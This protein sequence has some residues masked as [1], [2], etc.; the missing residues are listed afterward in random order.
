MNAD[1]AETARSGS[2]YSG[3]LGDGDAARGGNQRTP[4][5][6][7]FA[8][9]LRC[10]EQSGSA[11]ACARHV[12]SF[13]ACERAVFN[14]VRRA[15]PQVSSAHLVAHPPLHPTAGTRSHVDRTLPPPLQPPSGSVR[16]RLGRD[17][18]WMWALGG[19]AVAKQSEACTRLTHSCTEEGAAKR[20]IQRCGGLVSQGTSSVKLVA[21]R[22]SFRVMEE[23][24]RRS[25]G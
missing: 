22:L 12:D 9:M 4:C 14:A 23:W 15:H 21:E 19:R 7:R 1:D 18:E 8:R 20:L 2:G 6:V 3:S 13:L 24:K 17:A 5:G 11:A 16:E 10:V 25:G